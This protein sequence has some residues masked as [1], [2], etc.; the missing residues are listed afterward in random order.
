MV[1]LVARTFIKHCIYADVVL[2]VLSSQGPIEALCDRCLRRHLRF[3][4][5]FWGSSVARAMRYR[6]EGYCGKGLHSGKG[7]RLSH[8]ALGSYFVGIV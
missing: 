4:H 6:R 8:A 7:R 2:I 3:S 1:L 5:R